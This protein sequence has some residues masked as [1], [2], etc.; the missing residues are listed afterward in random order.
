MGAVKRRDEKPLCDEATQDKHMRDA[1]SRSFQSLALNPIWSD[2]GSKR[3]FCIP[4]NCALPH[5]PAM[6]QEMIG[7]HAS[8]HRFAHRNGAGIVTALGDDVG[9]LAEETKHS[10]T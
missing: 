8:H 2:S 9:L 10:P 4:S 7:E 3:A 1:A 6:A 5:L